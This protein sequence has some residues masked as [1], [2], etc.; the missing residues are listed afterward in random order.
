M[1]RGVCVQYTERA[2][3]LLLLLLEILVN[4]NTFNMNT[5][6]IPSHSQTMYETSC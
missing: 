3:S 2:L 6:V 5:L 1:L 4:M